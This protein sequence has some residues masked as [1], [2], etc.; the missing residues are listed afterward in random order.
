[1]SSRCVDVVCAYATEV[2]DNEWAALFPH[3]KLQS[4][5]NQGGGLEGEGTKSFMFYIGRR[6]SKTGRRME[7]LNLSDSANQ[8]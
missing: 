2:M 4:W 8:T 5:R 7:G 1:M 3:P 6:Q